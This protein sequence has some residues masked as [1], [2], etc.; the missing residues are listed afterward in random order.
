[1]A[2]LIPT[3]CIPLL[4]SQPHRGE[5][6]TL[7]YLHEQL[8][9]DFTVFHSVHWSNV[10]K[11]RTSFGEIDFVVVSPA[12]QVVVIEQKNGRLLETGKD[13]VKEYGSKQKNVAVQLHRNIEAIRKKYGKFNRGGLLIDYLYYFP[14]HRLVDVNSLA[15]DRSRIVD[16]TRKNQLVD[17]L[18]GL[19]RETEPEDNFDPARVIDFFKQSYDVKPDVSSRLAS[20]EQAFV[21]LSGGL[22]QTV[23]NLEF[24]PF[25]LRINGVAGCGK[26]QVAVEWFQSAAQASKKPL[27]VC[28]NRPLRDRMAMLCG[29]DS[30]LVETFHG[31]CVHALEAVGEKVDFSQSNQTGFWDNLVERVIAIDLLEELKFD[32]II[33]D[34]GQDFKELWLDVLKL[35]FRGDYELIW[36]EDRYQ[37]LRGTSDMNLPTTVTLKANESFRTPVSIARFIAETHD[38]PFK[39]GTWM[40]GMGVGVWGYEDPTEQ[41]VIVRER[42]KALRAEG[43]SSDDIV[44]LTCKGYQSSKLYELNEIS[45]A[46]LIKFTGKFDEKHNAIYTDGSL[47]FDSIH[48]FKGAQSPVV[49]LLDVDP[50]ERAPEYSQSTIFCGMTRATVRLEMLVNKNNQGNQPYLDNADN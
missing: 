46:K 49:I 2:K 45:G 22:T 24:S 8:P 36:L 5:I 32:R 23:R 17:I 4:K 25:R 40:P 21:S 3:D 29:N 18:K 13:L 12:G 48:R 14:D 41:L 16:A 6:E 31:L 43:F 28:F 9:D 19:L 38:I 35:F 7:A 20:G 50:S 42:L 37:N 15:L 1:V 27:Y 47:L 44:L 10:L 30:G 26:S 33:V 11:N 34:E 39:S